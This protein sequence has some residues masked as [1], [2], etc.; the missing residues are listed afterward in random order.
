MLTLPRCGDVDGLTHTLGS[1]AG[2]D[3]IEPVQK[4]GNVGYACYRKPLC[5]ILS[6]PKNIVFPFSSSGT[7]PLMSVALTIGKYIS[8]QSRSVILNSTELL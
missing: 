2:G 5:L 6:L 4:I 3:L 7:I 8:L 1:I